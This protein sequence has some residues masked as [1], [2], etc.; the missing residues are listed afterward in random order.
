MNLQEAWNL[1]TRASRGEPVPRAVLNE[2]W[3]V[4][5][6]AVERAARRRLRGLAA[7][8][9][10]EDVVQEVVV[11]LLREPESVR[12]IAAVIAMKVEQVAIDRHRRIEREALREDPEASWAPA[13]DA[14]PEA[15]ARAEAAVTG[16]VLRQE[17]EPRI[18]A[19]VAA[20]GAELPGGVP[21]LRESLALLAR[22]RRGAD[23]AEPPPDENR[24]RMARRDRRSLRE[25]LARRFRGA[26]DQAPG[27]RRAMGFELGPRSVDLLGDPPTRELV[28][29]LAEAEPGSPEADCLAWWL[30]IRTVEHRYAAYRRRSR[31]GLEP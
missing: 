20:V 16:R 30:A 26:W 8:A 29:R 12:R 24:A 18:E 31:A 19:A 22:R 13:R 3:A 11:K 10:I 7:E 9:E 25:W 15:E 21:R 2:T 6:Q 17:V 5:H 28:A 27:L 4:V 23:R 14:T 1:I